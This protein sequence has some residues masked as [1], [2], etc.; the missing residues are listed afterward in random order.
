MEGMS[1]I[2]YIATVRAEA[3]ALAADVLTGRADLLE[4][5]HKLSSL[6]S[7]AELEAG[8]EDAKAFMTISSEIDALPVG[9]ARVHWDPV[10]LARIQPE[11]DSAN[12]WARKIAE[13]ALV[14]LARRFKA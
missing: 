1:H 6:L 4:A 14:S 2:E 7:S 3:G 5:C 10:A 11:I 13:P 12:V 8:D 9:A